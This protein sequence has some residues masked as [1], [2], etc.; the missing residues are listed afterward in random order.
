MFRI[1]PLTRIFVPAIAQEVAHANGF[2]NMIRPGNGGSSGA[3]GS[4]QTRAG[5]I[6]CV[7]RVLLLASAENAT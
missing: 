3:P 1:A 6:S 4:D 5:S 2:W 7:K